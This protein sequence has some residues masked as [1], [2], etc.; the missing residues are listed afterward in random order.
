MGFIWNDIV[1]K[2]AKDI[3]INRKD[4]I[5]DWGTIYAADYQSSMCM[6]LSQLLGRLIPVSRDTLVHQSSLG[7]MQHFNRFSHFKLGCFT[8]IKGYPLWSVK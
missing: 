6:L 7:S 8:I 3:E 1:N 2:T 4:L 5:W